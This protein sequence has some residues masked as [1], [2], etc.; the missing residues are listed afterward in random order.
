MELWEGEKQSWIPLLNKLGA[1]LASPKLEV[2]DSQ[3][4]WN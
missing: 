3:A 1:V 4:L 2:S